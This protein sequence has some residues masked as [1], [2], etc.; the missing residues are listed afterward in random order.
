MIP[1]VARLTEA[2]PNRHCL[3]PLLYSSRRPCVC[4]FDAGEIHD[5]LQDLRT[6]VN[7]NETLFPLL[8]VLGHCLLHLR[9]RSLYQRATEDGH[10][11]LG[12]QHV[13]HWG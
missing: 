3:S 4:F 5:N 2:K 8:I 10:L 13:K 9:Y 6:I 1:E 11:H 7:I 12:H